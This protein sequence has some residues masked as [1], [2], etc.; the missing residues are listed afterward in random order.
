MELEKII[1]ELMD[2]VIKLEEKVRNLEDSVNNDESDK[3]YMSSPKY[4]HLTDYLINS[5]KQEIRMTFS[6]VEDILGFKL[7]PSARNHRP[8]WSNT[9]SLSLPKSWL[10][11]GYKTF[12][13]DMDKEIVHFVKVANLNYKI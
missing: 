9:D 2:R 13:V 11:A 4:R 6:Q 5:G 1:I 3:Q 7:A 10:S 12:D 8:S